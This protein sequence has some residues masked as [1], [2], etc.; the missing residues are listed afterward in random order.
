MKK[1][2]TYIVLLLTLTCFSK[3]GDFV[4]SKQL[5]QLWMDYNEDISSFLPIKKNVFQNKKV[6]HLKL[7]NL[8]LSNFL[9]F[10]NSSETHLFIENKLFLVCKER[11]Q[12]VIPLKDIRDFVGSDDAVITFHNAKGNLP[13]HNIFVGDYRISD[14]DESSNYSVLKR[15]EFK[16]VPLILF[17][18]FSGGILAFVKNTKPATY[19]AYFDLTMHFKNIEEHIVFN[20]FSKTSLLLPIIVSVLV[21]VSLNLCGYSFFSKGVEIVLWL[22]LVFDTLIVISFLFLKFFLIGIVSWMLDIRGLRRVYF[23]EFIRI[24]V[25]YAIF[26]FIVAVFNFGWYESNSTPIFVVNFIFFIFLLIKLFNTLN[27]EHKFS[28]LFLFFYFCTAEVFPLVVLVKQIA[29]RGL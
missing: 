29:Y 6:A 9:V 27:R 18:L 13:I 12:Q 28:Y 20:S 17:L 7:N 3:A 10:Q 26:L 24:S 1:W 19:Q 23:F 21:A 15:K 4:V 2:L 11:G 8:G 22:K 14:S 5:D 16:H 25:Q